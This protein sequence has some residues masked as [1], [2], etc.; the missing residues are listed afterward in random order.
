MEKVK[1]SDM[2]FMRAPINSIDMFYDAFNKDD[3]VDTL[4]S[5]IKNECFEYGMLISN[6]SFY[7]TVYEKNKD[8][9]GAMTIKEVNSLIAYA[10]RA[11]TRPTPYGYFAGIKAGMFAHMPRMNILLESP[12]KHIIQS[13]SSWIFA[14]IKKLENEIDII[15]KLKI[16]FNP[17]TYIVGGRLK[18][19]YISNFGAMMD[20]K[21]RSSIRVTNTLKFLIDFLSRPVVFSKVVQKLCDLYPQEEKIVLENYLLNLLSNEYIISELRTPIIDEEPLSHIV[22]TLKDCKVDS[23][24]LNALEK[25]QDRI[26]DYNIAQK[27]DKEKLV[28]ITNL[29][30]SITDNK[31]YLYSIIALD[32]T[33]CELPITVKD[34]VAEFINHLFELA[35]KVQELGA[36]KHYKNLFRSKYGDQMQVNILELFDSTIGLGNPYE[37]QYAQ[38]NSEYGVM[39]DYI[40]RK[41]YETIKLGKRT[42]DLDINQLKMIMADVEKDESSLSSALELNVMIRT[43]SMDHLYHGDFELVLGEHYGSHN[44]GSHINRFSRLLNDEEKNI[45]GKLY[46]DAQ[47]KN[48]ITVD[49]KE[50]PRYGRASNV[51]CGSQHYSYLSMGF[52]TEED[53]INLQDVFIGYDQKTDRLYAKLKSQNTILR[54]ISDNMLNMMSNNPYLRFLREI[55][56]SYDKKVLSII[57][58]IKTYEFPYSPKIRLG[59]TVIQDEQWIFKVPKNEQISYEEFVNAFLDYKRIWNMPQYVLLT[60]SDRRLMIDT[61]NKLW[62]GYLYKKIKKYNMLMFFTCYDLDWLK[63]SKNQPILSEYTFSITAGPTEIS[64]DNAVRHAEGSI[65][66]EQRVN[67][68]VESE[69]LYYKLYIETSEMNYLLSSL[70]TVANELLYDAAVDNMFFIRYADPQPHIRFRLN[71]KDKKELPRVVFTLSRYFSEIDSI[72]NILIDNYE[73]EYERYGGRSVYEYVEKLFTY[74]SICS[75]S[76]INYFI[77]NELEDEDVLLLGVCSYLEF[78]KAFFPNEEKLLHFL[79]KYVSEDDDKKYYLREKAKLRRK[80]EQ[81]N[82]L[83]AVG[84]CYLVRRNIVYDYVKALEKLRDNL[85]NNIENIMLSLAHMHC[86]RIIGKS[87]LEKT[88]MNLARHYLKDSLERQER[89]NT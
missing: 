19:P 55:S 59:K 40:K 52:F 1:V 57:S 81:Y 49:A 61:E 48:V 16:V 50:L 74:D 43:K 42:L 76:E 8:R 60:E 68:F 4:R 29:M 39:Q 47:Y 5:I 11:S 77:V 25:V 37:L 64:L 58:D 73:R 65:I 86:N 12:G 67:R 66:D 35:K 2:F 36:V 70:S 80:E 63:S 87:K 27:R 24:L 30:K 6:Q 53:S 69:W 15:S 31:E 22:G 32:G 54:V 41:V 18:N 62:I 23:P 72:S 28:E 79:N 85:P 20:Q 45:I 88:I 17:N 7:R 21:T 9:I 78:L 3:T 75:F 51:S 13:D 56:Y 84:E 46:Q 34:E 10:S 38:G 14:T 44:V 71:V 83:V 26:T 33:K 82:D 89:K